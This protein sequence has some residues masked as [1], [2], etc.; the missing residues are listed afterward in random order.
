[1]VADNTNQYV[2]QNTGDTGHCYNVSLLCQNGESALSQMTCVSVGDACN[3]VENLWYYISNEKP[4]ITWT[5]PENNENISAIYIFRKCND[6][7]YRRIKIVAPN[8]TEYKD[9]S[10]LTNGNWYYYKVCAYYSQDDCLSIPAKSMYG[11]EYFVKIYKSPEGVDEN[12]LQNIEVYPNPAK[13]VLTIKG[14]RIETVSVY[15]SI[16]QKVFGQTVDTDELTINTAGF[17]AGL[18]MVRIIADGGEI[19]RKVSVVR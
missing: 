4:V 10:V 19:T 7:E 14:D 12:E 17:D 8:K 3:P 15:N 11:N 2:D 1:M 18:Y 9:G 13:D 6:G 5:I 16:G